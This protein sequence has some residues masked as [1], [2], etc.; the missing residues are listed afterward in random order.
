MAIVNPKFNMDNV[1]SPFKVKEFPGGERN[2]TF[3]EVK[4]FYKKNG[5]YPGDTQEVIEL[6]KE[7]SE[8]KKEIEQMKRSKNVIWEK[9]G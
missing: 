2:L 7:I 1:S 4:D 9:D 3:G 8:L 6:R 5:H